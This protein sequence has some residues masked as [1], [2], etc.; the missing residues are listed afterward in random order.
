[1]PDNVYRWVVTPSL[2]AEPLSLADIPIYSPF[3]TDPAP[4]D[5]EM[6]SSPTPVKTQPPCLSFI[7]CT[8]YN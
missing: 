7:I 5:I 2:E 1:M 3:G 6:P 8:T 4:A